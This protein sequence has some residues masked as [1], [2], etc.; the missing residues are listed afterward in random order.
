MVKKIEIEPFCVMILCSLVDSYLLVLQL[1]MAQGCR[2]LITTNT[3][4]LIYL[5][6]IFYALFLLCICID[7]YT[8]DS[9]CQILRTCF[10]SEALWLTGIDEI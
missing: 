4:Y 8:S 6:S 3:P 9:V 2:I 7:L 1:I 10:I 5:L